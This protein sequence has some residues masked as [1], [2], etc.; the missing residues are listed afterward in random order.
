MHCQITADP[1]FARGIAPIGC[2][3][4]APRMPAV[5]RGT[6]PRSHLD[7]PLATIGCIL[8]PTRRV[9]RPPASQRPARRRR[10]N[11]SMKLSA[12]AKE[13]VADV[14]VELS[15]KEAAQAGSSAPI[16]NTPRQP[17]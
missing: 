2:S 13:A 1:G 15:Q 7:A 4:I 17:S 16:S 8:S 14:Q 5:A 3:A 6:T 9:G 10:K 12:T 11:Q